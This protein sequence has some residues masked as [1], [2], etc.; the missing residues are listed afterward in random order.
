MVR[1]EDVNDSIAVGI[2]VTMLALVGLGVALLTSNSNALAPLVS[3]TPKSPASLPP[4]G[5][6]YRIG[7]P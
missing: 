7:L 1:V 6:D 4:G 3:R 5:I 2:G